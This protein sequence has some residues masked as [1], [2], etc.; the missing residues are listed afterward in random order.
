MLSSRIVQHLTDGASDS[1]ERT[2]VHVFFSGEHESRGDP[3]AIMRSWIFQLAVHPE[4]FSLISQARE[5]DENRMASRVTLL[6]LLHKICQIVPRCFLAID[7]LD[8]CSASSDNSTSVPRFLED[9]LTVLNPGIR[10]LVVSRDEMD[11]RKALRYDAPGG[12]VV[13]YQITKGLWYIK[14]CRVQNW[15]G[16]GKSLG[17]YVYT[18]W[19]LHARAG[20]SLEQDSE[21]LTILKYFMDESRPEWMAWASWFEQPKIRYR[22]PFGDWASLSQ[23][24]ARPGHY[25][26]MYDL[27]VVVLERLRSNPSA[28]TL[29][30]DEQCP[31]FT[32]CEQGKSQV[33]QEFINHGA[34]LRA[35]TTNGITSL[36]V[37]LCKGNSDVLRL[38]LRHDAAAHVGYLNS[39][40][41]SINLAA[42]RG[43]LEAVQVLL[44]AGAAL[45]TPTGRDDSWEG[46]PLQA[47]ARYGELEVARYLIE[48]G[49]DIHILNNRG[50]NPLGSAAYHGFAEMVDL[51]ATKGAGVGGHCRRSRRHAHLSCSNPGAQGLCS[52]AHRPWCIILYAEA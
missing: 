15:D 39:R 27:D 4:A 51:L 35:S 21:T 44:E 25:P 14:T 43:H 48:K 33:V 2:V 26:L 34:N 13:E 18:H 28:E 36:A 32:A 24:P 40:I 23:G 8:G 52:E 41:S 45:N 5:D 31:F 22:F 50:W 17:G 12:R 29:V 10:I 16:R 19:L 42:G 20:L 47:A 30:D 11:I 46:T 6:K 38:L 37:A 1:P 49:A 3:Y 7:D 9:V